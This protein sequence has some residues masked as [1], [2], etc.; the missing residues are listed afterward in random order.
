M[1][2]RRILVGK[3]VKRDKDDRS[4]FSPK[5]AWQTALLY[6]EAPGTEKRFAAETAHPT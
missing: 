1:G 3:R 4:Q 2:S 5:S 6:H